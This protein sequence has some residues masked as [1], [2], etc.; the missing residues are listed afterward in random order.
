[1]TIQE[2]NKLI[3][4]NFSDEDGNVDISELEFD[5][6]VCISSLKVKGDLYQGYHNV[7]GDLH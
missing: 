1:M 7:E 2:L 3:I 4:D 6:N 5:H